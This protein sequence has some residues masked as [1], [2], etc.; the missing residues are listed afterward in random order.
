MY[1]RPIEIVIRPKFYFDFHV[2][3][4]YVFAQLPVV[5]D[6]GFMDTRA[7]EAGLNAVRMQAPGNLG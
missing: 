3:Y 6:R 7:S 5:A 2:S 1:A 4:A